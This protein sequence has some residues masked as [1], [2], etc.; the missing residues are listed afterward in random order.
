MEMYFECR[1][2]K[3]RTPPDCLDFLKRFCYLHCLHH[4]QWCLPYNEVHERRSTKSH[5]G[6]YG[7]R[8]VGNVKTD[9]ASSHNAQW[10]PTGIQLDHV[11]QRMLFSANSILVHGQGKLQKRYAAIPEDL[12]V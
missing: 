12:L 8:F 2:N 6:C 4:F 3:K 1:I 5:V 9:I 11:F 10:D 7:D